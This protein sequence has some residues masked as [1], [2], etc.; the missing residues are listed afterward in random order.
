MAKKTDSFMVTLKMNDAEY[1]TRGATLKEALLK[2]K[3]PFYKSKPIL[4]VTHQGKVAT[5]MVKIPV[6]KRLLSGREW[7]VDV[8]VK[9]L[10]LILNY[11]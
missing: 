8:I 3:P 7:A 2:L 6:L 5:R 1:K 10:S 4:V 11:K 9:Q